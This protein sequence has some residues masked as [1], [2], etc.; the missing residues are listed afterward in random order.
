[1]TRGGLQLVADTVPALLAYLDDGVR[2]VWANE[3]Y[4]RWFGLSLDSIRGRSMRDIVGRP[5][6]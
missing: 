5:P 2:Y 3:T 1:M 4:R 6:G